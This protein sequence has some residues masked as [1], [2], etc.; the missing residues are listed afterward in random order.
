MM[1]YKY[2]NLPSSQ[3]HEEKIRLQGA[4][5]KLLPYKEDNYELL[6]KYFVSIQQR[7]NGLNILFGEQAKIITLMSILEHARY[8][9]DFKE[10]RK[11]ILDACA[12]VDEIE[13][14]DSDI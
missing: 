3:I 4:I 5:Y 2:G 10:Y 1:V 8:E 11:A 6:D 12:L 13:E 9:D 7:I 14:G